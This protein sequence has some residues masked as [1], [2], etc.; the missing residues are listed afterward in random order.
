MP[1]LLPLYMKAPPHEGA[2][3]PFEVDA[4]QSASQAI[5]IF[6]DPQLTGHTRL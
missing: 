4:W 2:P 6:S 5:H 3:D 1:H